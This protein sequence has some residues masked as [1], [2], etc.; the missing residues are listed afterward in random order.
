MKYCAMV[1]AVLTLQGCG[2][3]SLTDDYQRD[4][5]VLYI[6]GTDCKMYYSEGE[7]DSGASTGI[8]KNLEA[9]DLH[10]HLPDELTE[11]TDGEQTEAAH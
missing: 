10:Q 5:M 6:T 9:A 11:D 7:I 8:T 1:L 2:A 4:S 3:W